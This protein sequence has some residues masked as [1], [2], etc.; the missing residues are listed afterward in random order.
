MLPPPLRAACA[1]G[2]SR[3][4][5]RGRGIAAAPPAC[6]ASA[7]A[8]TRAAGRPRRSRGRRC[9]IET[10]CPRRSPRPRPGPAGNPVALA[11]AGP[12]RSFPSYPAGYPLAHQPGTI[13][14]FAF[15]LIGRPVASARRR[16][17]LHFL[18]AARARQDSRSDRQHALAS[19]SGCALGRR[20]TARPLPA[21]RPLLPL[22][23]AA[24]RLQ[25]QRSASRRQAFC[26][27]PLRRR[28]ARSLAQPA[29][30]CW[31]RPLLSL[32]TAP[33]RSYA[34]RLAARIAS[35]GPPWARACLFLALQRSPVALCT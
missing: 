24:S 22:L 23:L 1:S 26:S 33:R 17:T 18:V 20:R 29:S 3:R 5:G 14:G 12:P 11:T 7:P 32:T 2:P 19:L 8:R 34:S 25:G 30:I 31:R 16:A 35:R 9:R 27:H 15:G 6:A 21:C 10:K 28:L 4:L 13:T